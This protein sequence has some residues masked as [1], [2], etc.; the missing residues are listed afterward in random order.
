MYAIYA[1]LWNVLVDFIVKYD[2]SVPETAGILKMAA[3]LNIRVASIL[4]EKSATLHNNSTP[5]RND[6]F[7]TVSQYL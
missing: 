7:R 4:F 5:R 2:I 1:D 6:I 3:I